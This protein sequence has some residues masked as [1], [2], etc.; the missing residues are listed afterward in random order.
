MTKDL[1]IG[2]KIVIV[3]DNENY[4][5]YRDQ[6]HVVSHIAFNDKQHPGYD[7]SMEGEGLIDCIDLP[8]SLY[9]YEFKIIG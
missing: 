5:R 9:E 2:S 8:F 1:H 4:D 7:S 3:S 6:I